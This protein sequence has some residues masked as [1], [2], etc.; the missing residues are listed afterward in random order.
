MTDC[1]P[2]P[3]GLPH[4]KVNRLEA[5]LAAG[6]FRCLVLALAGFLVRLPALQGEPIWDDD[7]LVRANPFIKSPLLIL[8]VFRHYLFQDMFTAAYRPVQNLSYLIDYMVWNNNFYGYHLTSVLCHVASGVLLYLLLQR[9]LPSLRIWPALSA[10]KRSASIPSALAFFV[11]LLW[12]VHPVHSAAVDYVSGR[13]DSLAFLFATL[14]WLLFIKA[15]SLSNGWASSLLFSAAWFAGLLALCAR[16][17]GLVWIAIFCVFTFAFDESSTRWS[18]WMSLL[19]CAS[20]IGVYSLLRALPGPASL[21]N[22]P[23]DQIPPF[24]RIVLMFRALGDYAGLILFPSNLHMERTVYD[25]RAFQSETGRWNAIGYEYLSIAGVMVLT[26]LVVLSLRAGRGKPLRI[27]G[28]IWFMVAFLPISNLINLN[29]TVAEH[30]LYLPSVGLLLFLAGCGLDLPP[31]YHRAAAAFACI[32][33]VALGV[34]SAYRSSDW[35]SNETFARRTIAA[36]GASD[37]VVLLLGQAYAK[38][39]DYAAAERLLRLA[40]QHSPDYPMA[41]NNLADALSHQ[42]RDK[43]AEALFAKSTETAA[44]DRQGYSQTWVAALN[45]SHM[46]HK[47]HDDPGAIAV[48]EKA[49]QNYPGT[50]ELISTEA[51]LLRE[52]DQTDAALSVVGNFAQK[53]WWHYPAWTGYGRLLA[54]KGDVEGAAAA[55]RHASRLDVHETTALNLMAQIW[56]QQNRPEEALRTQKRAV[57]RQPDEPR[58]YLLLSE[59]LDKMGRN[60]EAR[61]ALAQVSRL[62]ELAEP[63]TA[64]N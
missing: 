50:W 63:R 62:R 33:V 64:Q 43:E 8:E 1:D 48:L 40:V 36:G 11:A 38:R 56:M 41:R 39:G 60:D 16:E 28:T 31:R 10:T 49:R 2:A 24:L 20:I 55:L 4:S 57:S 21:P 30:W 46:L 25:P 13:A 23:A 58:Q 54:Q 51:E 42:G 14:A 17:S 12:I 61:S 3:E 37:R 26:S 44:K 59:I 45:L 6:W 52:T 34:R 29:A 18:R 32:A 7:Y 53:N 27:L 15:R 35:A 22:D 5:W 19:G 47:Q 9:L